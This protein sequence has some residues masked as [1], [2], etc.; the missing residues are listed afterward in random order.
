M[1]QWPEHEEYEAICPLVL[2]NTS[3]EERA[4]EEALKRLYSRFALNS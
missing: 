2:F 3:V 1:F 4:E